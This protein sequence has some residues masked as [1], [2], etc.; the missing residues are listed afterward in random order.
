MLHDEQC[1]LKHAWMREPDCRCAMRAYRRDPLP[2]VPYEPSTEDEDDWL[3]MM[4]PMTPPSPGMMA[5]LNQWLGLIF[6]AR[7][8]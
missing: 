4:S 7:A 6:A 8:E 1:E 2:G 5:H 3:V